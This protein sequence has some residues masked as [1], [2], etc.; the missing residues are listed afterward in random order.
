MWIEMQHKANK[1][2]FSVQTE[3]ERGFFEVVSNYSKV[4]QRKL[5][6]F[7]FEDLILVQDECWQRG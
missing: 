1:D 3:K 5:I 7:L 2:P 6:N 4:C